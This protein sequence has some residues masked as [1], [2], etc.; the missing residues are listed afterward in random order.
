M[1]ERAGY[2]HIERYNDNPYA[3]AWFEKEL[4][5]LVRNPSGVRRSQSSSTGSSRASAHASSWSRWC[6]DR[7]SPAAPIGTTQPLRARSSR[8]HT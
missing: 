5:T 1:Y 4:V 6:D 2:R 3:Q 8:S 7:G